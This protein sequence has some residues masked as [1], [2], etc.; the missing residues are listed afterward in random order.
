MPSK[1]IGVANETW[2]VT[3]RIMNVACLHS[4]EYE[5]VSRLSPA[6]LLYELA[7]PSIRRSLFP[8]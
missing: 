7:A 4:A 3:V 5:R 6:A 8:D 2:A 1:N